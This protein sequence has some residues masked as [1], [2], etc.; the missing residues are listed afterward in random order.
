[1]THDDAR[2][3]LSLTRARVRGTTGI[4]RHLASWRHWR[5]RGLWE[6]ASNL[7][8]FRARKREGRFARPQNG[9]RQLARG[10]FEPH[11]APH[12]PVPPKA[13]MSRAV[14]RR[15]PVCQRLSRPLR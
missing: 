2:F 11:R 5:R 10:A 7:Y 9:R 1:M 13:R 8:T 14:A 6:G 12:R 4:R 15:R 3:P